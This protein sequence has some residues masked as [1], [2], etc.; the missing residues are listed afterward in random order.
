VEGKM[1]DK[2]N[3][4]QQELDETQAQIAALEVALEDKPDY[5]LGS[6]ASGVTRWELNRAML[7]RLREHAAG[8]EQTLSQAD[9]ATYGICERCGRSIHPD[10][11][12][13]L[14][15]TTICVRCA[16]IDE[17]Q[18]PALRQDVLEAESLT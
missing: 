4:L 9:E 5:G 12:A 7:Q 11:L 13:V 16:H 2:T 1:K 17:G 18:T 6:G 14:P 3:I 15:H 10:R 8:L